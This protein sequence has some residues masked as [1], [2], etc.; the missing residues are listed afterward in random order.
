[1]ASS[2]PPS[3]SELSE[4]LS[5]LLDELEDV[6]ATDPKAALEL[7][8]GVDE[9]FASHPII[10]L[11]RAQVIWAN[12]DLAGARALLTQLVKDEPDFSDAH[13]AL[14]GVL[15]ELDEDEP[16]RIQHLLKVREIDTRDDEA[17]G[18]DVKQYEPQIVA[19]AEQTL[20][21]LPAPFKQALK[22][23]PI[24]L[25]DRPSKAL[26]EDGFD[27]RALGLFEGPTHEDR[28]VG[29]V[30]AP[31]RV[32]LFTANLSGEFSDE[33]ELAEE[34]RITLLHEIGHYFGLE[35]DDMERLGLD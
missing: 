17:D 19:A 35:E 23:L 32:V 22:G 11:A 12:D 15:T 6:I 1:M 16:A 18:F 8:D 25:E 4:Q 29:D 24:L 7:L 21:T 33:Q 3:D 13:Y 31:S 26:V 27:P 34:V 30:P 9:A 14:A 10:R 2:S 5:E 28:A 20:E